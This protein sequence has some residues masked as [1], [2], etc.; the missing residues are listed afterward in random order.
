[1]TEH[2]DPQE[3]RVLRQIVNRSSEQGWGI[4][5]GLTLALGLLVAT[6]ILVVRGGPNVGS[7]LSMLE[8]YFPGYSVSWSGGLIGFVYT[9]VLGYAIGR[10][11]AT[12]Y[13]KLD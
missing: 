1:M 2:F 11:V 10:T 9:F 13:N 8:V 6:L 7:H 4:A 3:E 12:L 5:V